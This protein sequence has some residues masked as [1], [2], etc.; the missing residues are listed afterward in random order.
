M[1]EEESPYLKYAN[2]NKKEEKVI[3]TADQRFN[4]YKDILKNEKKHQKLYKEQ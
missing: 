4:Q 1:E 3:L 2:L